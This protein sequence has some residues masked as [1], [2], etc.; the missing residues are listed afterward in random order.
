[1]GWLDSHTAHYVH[2][3]T[4]TWH[5][6]VPCCY[7]RSCRQGSQNRDPDNT[8][9][10]INQINGHKTA[11][12]TY[13]IRFLLEKIGRPMKVDRAF[14]SQKPAGFSWFCEGKGKINDRL[15]GEGT[16]PSLVQIWQ[17]ITL[18]HIEFILLLMPWLVSRWSRFDS[19]KA[20]S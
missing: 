8:N 19:I 6:P 20:P 10:W 17:R 2:V 11:F 18:G 16:C 1:V 14:F 7:E 4:K 9:R 3:I 15:R 13:Q 12:A 5:F